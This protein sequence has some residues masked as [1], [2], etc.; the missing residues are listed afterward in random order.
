MHFDREL[1]D[2]IA[3]GITRGK[4]L[5]VE[6]IPLVGG[7]SVRNKL[8]GRS[9]R[10]W[11]VPFPNMHVEQDPDFAAIG[12]L[13]ETVDGSTHTFN[14]RDELNGDEIVRVRFEGQLKEVHEDGPY[15]RYETLMLV[16]EPNEDA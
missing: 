13:F 11:E 16:E 1:P 7:G 9:L 6:I 4:D 5:N 8:W 10:T 14:F 12:D 3:R 15:W 2:R